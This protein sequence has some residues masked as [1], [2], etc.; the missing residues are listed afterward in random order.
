M[1]AAAV[2]ATAVAAVAV[3]PVVQCQPLNFPGGVK[4]PNCLYQIPSPLRNL[5]WFLCHA[6]HSDVT[7]EQQLEEA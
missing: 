4:E 5:N 2:T 1:V 7:S 3:S 6:L